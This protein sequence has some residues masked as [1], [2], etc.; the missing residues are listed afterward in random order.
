MLKDELNGWLAD[1]EYPPSVNVVFILP[2]SAAIVPAMNI[3][4]FICAN[5]ATLT[6]IAKE[7][8]SNLFI[9]S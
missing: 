1:A 8:N 5:D 2:N 3:S 4:P 6:S 7:N 9:L